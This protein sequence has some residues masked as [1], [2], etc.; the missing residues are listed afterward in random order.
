MQNVTPF[1]KQTIVTKKQ[2][3]K[4]KPR[5]PQSFSYIKFAEFGC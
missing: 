3:V 4:K 5:Q 1:P 2:K